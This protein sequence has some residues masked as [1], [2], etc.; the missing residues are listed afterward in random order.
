[1][2]RNDTKRQKPLEEFV[3]DERRRTLR[4]WVSRGYSYQQIIDAFASLNKAQISRIVKEDENKHKGGEA[5]GS[6]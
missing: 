1:M 5:H 4:W 6:N 3:K 2:K